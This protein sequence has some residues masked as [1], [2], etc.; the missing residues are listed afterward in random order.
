MVSEEDSGL[1]RSCPGSRDQDKVGR[2]NKRTVSG[3]AEE[4]RLLISHEEEIGPSFLRAV[5]KNLNWLAALLCPAR[6]L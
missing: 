4:G 5:L 6:L 2:V 3:H 1:W